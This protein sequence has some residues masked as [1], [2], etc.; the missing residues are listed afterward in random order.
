[1]PG[2]HLVFFAFRCSFWFFVPTKYQNE[3]CD[4]QMETSAK[5]QNEQQKHL[6]VFVFEI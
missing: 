5:N 1:M 6:P 4:V 2:F 3:K